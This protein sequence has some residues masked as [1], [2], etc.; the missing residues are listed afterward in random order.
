ME[1]SYQFECKVRGCNRGFDKKSSLDLHEVLRHK[2]QP[3]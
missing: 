1:R 3:N 2:M